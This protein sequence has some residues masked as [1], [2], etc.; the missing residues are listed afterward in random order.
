MSLLPVP[1]PESWEHTDLAEAHAVALATPVPPDEQG[2]TLLRLFRL[3]MLRQQAGRADRI[4]ASGDYFI[5]TGATSEVM[6]RMAT[7]RFTSSG[8]AEFTL[9]QRSP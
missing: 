1:R 8:L 5:A 6:R 2:R 4:P 3:A 7:R 9:R